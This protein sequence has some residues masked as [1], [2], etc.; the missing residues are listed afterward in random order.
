MFKFK[1][2][3]LSDLRQSTNKGRLNG[4][5]RHRAHTGI[6][7]LLLFI[8]AMM[9]NF[10]KTLWTWWRLGEDALKETEKETGKE[11][12]KFDSSWVTQPVEHTS[13]LHHWPLVGGFSI[14]NTRW[15]R[16]LQLKH[17]KFA[18]K[19]STGIHLLFI[20]G[21]L[22]TERTHRWKFFTVNTRW[23]CYLQ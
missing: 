6:H 19:I 22:Q 5:L 11:E 12:L 13:P 23:G 8:I 4:R 16:Y 9:G 1:C 3:L 15:G 18:A 17:T 14:V 20:I 10:S 7:L 21:V 2:K